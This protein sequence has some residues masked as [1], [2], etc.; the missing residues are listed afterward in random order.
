MKPGSKIRLVAVLALYAVQRFGLFRLVTPLVSRV[1]RLSRG[2]LLTQVGAKFDDTV[3]A[4][5]RRS[6]ALLVYALM[7]TISWLIGYLET[8]IR[9]LALG[10][11]TSFI[12]ALIVDTAGQGV[13]SVLFIVPAGLGVFEGGTVIICNLLV[14]QILNCRQ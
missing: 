3:Q 10:I 5:Y 13:R 14:R 11:Q 1:K 9:L 4:I 12:V 7:W 8:W 2:G 6:G